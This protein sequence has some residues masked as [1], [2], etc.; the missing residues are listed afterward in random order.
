MIVIEKF[1][2]NLCFADSMVIRVLPWS[3][4]EY[5]VLL[6]ILILLVRLGNWGFIYWFRHRCQGTCFV[7]V[8]LLHLIFCLI[9]KF[10]F[11]CLFGFIYWG[12]CLVDNDTCTKSCC[13]RRV[14]LH[15]FKVGNGFP[16]SLNQ[17]IAR[18]DIM[19]V[20]CVRKWNHSRAGQAPSKTARYYSIKSPNV[21][22]FKLGLP[23]IVADTWNYMLIFVAM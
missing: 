4:I 22:L 18:I 13:V 16:L 2:V 17:V 9:L 7:I 21:V 8:I 10:V 3:F 12:S 14:P 20:D 6:L 23:T 19:M 1:E 5:L 11:I 15:F